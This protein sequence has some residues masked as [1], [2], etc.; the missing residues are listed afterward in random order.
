MPKFGAE[1]VVDGLH[2]AE[3]LPQPTHRLHESP[4]RGPARRSR[5]RT[6]EHRV[7]LLVNR[8]EVLAT[9]HSKQIDDLLAGH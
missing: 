4:S 2:F 9:G 5:T 7:R 8:L 6:H 3:A 1:H